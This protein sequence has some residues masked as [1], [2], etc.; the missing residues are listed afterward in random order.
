MDSTSSRAIA[1]FLSG[2]SVLQPFVAQWSP[3][4]KHRELFEKCQALAA[5]LSQPARLEPVVAASMDSYPTVALGTQIFSQWP[6]INNPA[7][8]VTNNPSPDE[9][10]EIIGPAAAPSPSHTPAQHPRRTEAETLNLDH[11]VPFIDA[12]GSVIF[13]DSQ[14]KVEPVTWTVGDQNKFTTASSSMNLPGAGFVFPLEEGV[15]EN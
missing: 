1:D 12:F 3:Q 11:D 5:A 7:P 10:E 6:F 9:M 14:G 13:S 2:A 15:T 8:S 4:D